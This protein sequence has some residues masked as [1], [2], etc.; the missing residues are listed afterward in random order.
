MNLSDFYK[1]N[2]SVT[3][4][5][6]IEPVVQSTNFTAVSN[7]IYKIDASLTMTLPASPDEGDW[8]GGILVNNYKPSTDGAITLG[9]NSNEVF[10]APENG[11]WDIDANFI[12]QYTT[13]DGWSAV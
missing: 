6:D 3:D 7:K 2:Q 4:F 10:N 1:A 9:R 13:Q 12:L 8:V 5:N 11:S